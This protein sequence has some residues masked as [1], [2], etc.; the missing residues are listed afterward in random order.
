MDRAVARL[1][2]TDSAM[3]QGTLRQIFTEHQ[4][5]VSDKWEH[6]LSIYDSA[7]ARFV[8]KGEPVRLLEIGVQNGGS[9]QI[10]SKYLPPGSTIVGIDVDPACAQLS[11]A[12]NI[13]IL[14]C[15]ASDPGALNCNLADA[16]FDIIID[17]GSHRSDDVVATFEACFWRLNPGGIYIIEDM[18]ASY[19]PS[20]GG[21]FRI[22]GTSIEWLKGLLDALN[23]D[24]FQG[25][26]TQKLDAPTLQ[27]LEALGRQIACITIFDSVALIEKLT[28]EKDGPYRRIMTGQHAPVVDM[29][30]EIPRLR[31]RD[32]LLPPATV[33]A[34]TPAMLNVLAAA[35]EHAEQA[36]RESEA[37]AVAA[38]QT[39]AAT[40]QRAAAIEQVVQVLRDHH[41]AS[42]TELAA[43][44]RELD[45]RDSELTTLRQQISSEREAYARADAD[46]NNQL[47]WYQCR[48]DDIR[49]EL[50]RRDGEFSNTIAKHRQRSDQFEAELRELGRAH[51]RLVNSRSWRITAPVRAVRERHPRIGRV[52]VDAA[53]AAWWIASFRYSR[54]IDAIRARSRARREEQLL[55]DSGL[56][57]AE[58]YVRDNPEAAAFGGSPTWHYL[59][60]GWWD[61][62]R[63]HPLFDGEWYRQR[64]PD[65]AEAKINPLVHFIEIGMREYRD[66]NPFFDMR[67]YATMNPDIAL[68]GMD[69][70]THFIK[71]GA[72]HRA[73]PSPAFSTAWY[74]SQYPDIAALG[75]NPL[76]HYLTSGQ[77]EGRWPKLPTPDRD[78]GRP[79]TAAKIECRKS[80]SVQRETALFVTHSPDGCLKPHVPG[81]LKALNREGIG[82]IL[83]V[84]ADRGLIEDRPG[85]YELVDGLFV[86]ANEGFDFAAWAH[87]LRLHREIY[88]AEILYL[89][90]DSVVGPVSDSAFHAAIERIRASTS[91]LVGMTDNH[92]RGWHLQS[93]FLALKQG[94]LRAYAWQEFIFSILSLPTKDDVINSYEVR[95]TP[96]LVA[97]GISA[98]ALFKAKSHIGPTIYRWKELLE[99]GF[100]FIKLMAIRDEFPGVDRGGWRRKLADFDYDVTIVD[101]LLTGKRLRLPDRGSGELRSSLLA[102]AVSRHRPPH[103]TF[104]GPWNYDN[105]L[106]V[107]S[108]GYVAALMR[109]G[110][111]TNFH[112]F[113]RPFHI[114]QRTGP[115]LEC[116][117]FVGPPDI[118]V[119]HANP[120]GWD[121]L[122]T[123]AQMDIIRSA[124]LKI[125]AFIWESQQLPLEFHR[126]FREFD[127]VWAPTYYCTELFQASTGLPV[128]TVH[129]P[130]GVPEYRRGPSEIASIKEWLDLGSESKLILFALD[131]SSYLARKNPL[132]LVA[133]FEQTDLAATE[134]HLILKVKHSSD[135]TA[136]AKALR[137]RIEG[138]QGAH[139]IDRPMGNE[140]MSALMEAADI[141][142]S[143]HSSE[144]F[145]LTIAEEMALGNIVVATD[146]GGSRDFLDGE[147]GFP[148]RWQPWKIDRDDGAYAKGTVWAKIDEGHLAES[149]VAAAALSDDE[150]RRI[151]ERARR[152]VRDT[153]S[154]EAVAS[155][156]QASINSLLAA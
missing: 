85:L 44:R 110:F 71:V 52:L 4:G 139:L 55:A 108:R 120:D 97:A 148:V 65:V 58:F 51:Y 132:A 69:P 129:F 28:V 45:V 10:W 125:G 24:H 68:S 116:R 128:H 142:A 151:G 54:L 72:A 63:P 118:V 122:L 88:R 112:A 53:Q 93:Y 119:V 137:T 14:I 84:A 121:G 50:Q 27:Y 1:E 141:Y 3:P 29:A 32:L 117:N 124:P 81:Y 20:H 106:G 104:I 23:T 143:P 11:M 25:D 154:P 134:W 62:Y 145:G 83:I 133:A 105:G 39:A 66:P 22:P 114:H 26:V 126:R 31:G 16:H 147:T 59:V 43:Q 149:L 64:N 146:Y 79:V 153:L 60:R 56:F 6:Y 91:D 34:F 19:F 78:S 138:C 49:G 15:N 95:L 102:P 18:H 131:A 76:A 48:L 2:F 42:E 41:A 103:V 89:L 77:R 38:E 150:K 47:N 7:L 107:A 156:M 35:R 136:G 67:W 13:T 111:A 90:N 5:F 33:A 115:I 113:A 21:G 98:S 152:R 36:Q 73:D 96:A 99:E 130:V 144:G 61:G 123:E 8:E 94:A 109:A 80:P 101:E 74:L 100:P 40:E 70:L 12:P 92:E 57:D 9:L 87:V 30:A 82:V 37:R 46:L 127:A 75:I 135:D 140:G 17:D 86:R 155:E